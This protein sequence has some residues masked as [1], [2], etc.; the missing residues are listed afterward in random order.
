MPWRQTA[1]HLRA[2][3]LGVAG[4]LAAV[5]LRRPDVLALAVPFL[6]IAVWGHVTR[7]TS[8]AVLSFPDSHL[9]ATDDESNVSSDVA[10]QVPKDVT[11]S[12]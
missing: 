4:A 1:A 2:A 10:A 3:V 6:V 5:L 9:L 8:Q 12:S 11:C 7:P